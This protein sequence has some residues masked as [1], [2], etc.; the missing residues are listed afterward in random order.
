MPSNIRTT[1]IVVAAVLLLS[2]PAIADRTPVRPGWNLFTTQ[3]DIEMGRALASDADSALPLMG[4]SD[5]TT[6]LSALG[7]QLSRHAP[8]DR[9]SYQFRIIDDGEANAFA[10]PGGYIYVSRGAIE[11]AENEPQLAGL[12]AHQ[13]AH[14]ALRHGTQQVSSAYADQQANATRGRVSVPTAMSRLNLRFENNSPVLKYTREMEQQADIVGAQI[15]RD[16]S[17]DPRQMTRM[18]QNLVA[19]SPRMTTDFFQN[20]PN[21]TNRA[22]LIRTEMQN[23]G[24]LPSPLRGDSNDFHTVKNML[25]GLASDSDY[26]PNTGNRPTGNRPDLPST[27][28][29]SYRG[30]DLNLRYPDNWTVDEEADAVVLAPDGGY[31]NGSLAFGMRISSF[32]PRQT[33]YYGDGLVTP[34]DRVQRST[35]SSATDQLIAQLQRSNPNMRVA[36]SMQSK[37]VGGEAGLAVELSNDSPTGGREVDWLVTSLRPNGTLRYFI[38]VAPQQDVNRYMP[39]FEQIVNSVRFYD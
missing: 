39:S 38:G 5:A 12:L 15:M 25:E 28:L 30:S 17:F 37:T 10:L 32:Q 6:Y 7:S 18:F 27:R 16:T 19:E 33:R 24:G 34:G 31:V 26:Y 13:I 29:V 21:L 2:L 14:I 23:M 22:A 36:R 20:H 11:A 35:I 4:T 9:Y 8:G 3:Q 1:I